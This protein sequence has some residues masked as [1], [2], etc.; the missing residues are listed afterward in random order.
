MHKIVPHLKVCFE[1][2]SEIE[3]VVRSCGIAYI[4]EHTYLQG[5]SFII[6]NSVSGK[7]FSIDWTLE[8]GTIDAAEVD[9]V[10]DLETE[11]GNVCIPKLEFELWY[12]DQ[13]N[14]LTV[15]Y[16]PEDNVWEYSND[17]YG[18]LEGS[19]LNKL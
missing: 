2:M 13:E 15:S 16:D 1:K 12:L 3:R 5:G 17:G 8:I 10:E 6:K 9:D 4:S 7:T 14:L 11:W 19:I 18:V